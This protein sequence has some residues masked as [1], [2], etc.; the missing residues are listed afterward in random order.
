MIKIL[1]IDDEESIVNVLS[2]SLRSDGF[3]VVTAYSGEEGL[4]VYEKESPHIVITDLKMPGIDGFE[5]LK[6]MK[7]LN[8]NTEVI[9]ITG[10]GDMDSAIEAMQIGASDFINKPVR[11]DALTIALDRAKEKILI[12]QQLEDYTEDLENM[13]QMA[14]DEL[15]RKSELQS[16][17]ISSS[18]D[19]I[20]AT[21]EIGDIVIYNP[22]AS[23]IFGYSRSE[24]IRK[25]DITDLFPS[26]IAVEVCEGLKEKKVT[27]DYP[28]KE[29]TI[30]S[31]D[32][33]EVPTRF[34]WTLL[35]EKDQL[36]GSVVF[37]HDL[38]EIKRLE[39][40]LVRSERLAAVGQT[41]AGLA[42]YIKNI[43]TGL[44]GGSYIA[45][46]GFAKKDLKQLS[47]GWEMI[48]K[49]IGTISDLV[50]ELLTYSK[51]REPD[52]KNIFPNEMAEDV[53]E[54]MDGKAKE[55]DIKIIRKFASAATKAAMDPQFI[56]RSL[57]N[58]VSN[59]IDACIFDE[60]VSKKY[61]VRVS[62]EMD[63]ENVIFEVSDNGCGMSDKVKDKLFTN[64]FSTKMGKGTGF[65]L[66]VTKKLIEEHKGKLGYKSEDKKGS[67]FTITLPFMLIEDGNNKVEVKKNKK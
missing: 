5:V 30:H 59:A 8:R 28:W 18:N 10:H 65:G 1:L 16:K 53:C 12:R 57:L 64:F 26:E 15:K 46:I 45:N 38:R 42:H 11:D 14:T 36:I 67:T 21:D 37:L 35:M 25:K 27:K 55:N 20:I 24:I 29:V 61:K 33:E 17:L 22:G 60:D 63:K 40:E 54:L 9:V 41:V 66:M 2:L 50:L 34:S 48:Q 32:E 58:L 7:E 31:K 19:G 47:K 62:T 3:D 13:V 56:H 43:L 39:K 4:G 52:Y 51:E 23:K 49:N 44:K 6:K